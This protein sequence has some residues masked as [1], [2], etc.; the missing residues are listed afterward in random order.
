MPDWTSWNEVILWRQDKKL[1]QTLQSSSSGNH[2]VHEGQR[3]AH[4]T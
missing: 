2:L 3:T 1:Q 4:E